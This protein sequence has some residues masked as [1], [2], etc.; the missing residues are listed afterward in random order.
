[1]PKKRLLRPKSIWDIEQVSEAFL[2]EG[3]KQIHL[4]K[5]YTYVCIGYVDHKQETFTAPHLEHKVGEYSIDLTS[6]AT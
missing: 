2:R 3:I 6:S 4:Q 5:L 1:M